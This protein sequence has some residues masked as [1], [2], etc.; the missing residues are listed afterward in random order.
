MP[1]RAQP[2]IR[3]AAMA[4]C[5]P[6]AGCLGGQDQR[7][8][9]ASAQPSILTYWCG[10]GGPLRLE[11]LA[12]SVRLSDLDGGIELPASPAGQSARFARNPY[13]VILDGPHA[14]LARD[15]SPPIACTR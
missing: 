13:T 5:L 12:G 11:R 3:I 1:I 14:T 15:G 10:D 6:F 8:T 9:P 7:A 4:A 2:F